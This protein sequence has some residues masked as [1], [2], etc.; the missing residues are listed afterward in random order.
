MAVLPERP[1]GGTSRTPCDLPVSLPPRAYDGDVSQSAPVISWVSFEPAGPLDEE[2]D[3]LPGGRRTIR[4]V[5]ADKSVTDIATFYTDELRLAPQDLLGLTEAQARTL[6]F[7]TDA[8]Y[9]R[10]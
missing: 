7:A 3:R 8:A 10:S 6:L 1:S 9:L 5:F 2:L 4:V